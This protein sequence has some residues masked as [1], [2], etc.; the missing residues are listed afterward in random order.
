MKKEHPRCFF[1]KKPLEYIQRVYAVTTPA[2]LGF[3][4]IDHQVPDAIKRVQMESMPYATWVDRGLGMDVVV[5][6]EKRAP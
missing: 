3:A 1:C 4:H 6:T 2:G 5:K